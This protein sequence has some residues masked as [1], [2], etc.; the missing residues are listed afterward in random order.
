MHITP[1]DPRE[2]GLSAALAPIF[3]AAWYQLRYPEI[4]AT[5]LSP[6]RHFIRG[7]LV[8]LRD[9]NRFFDC[10]W[11]GEHYPDVGLSGLHPL[12]HYLRIGA[13]E[14]RDPH[15]RFDASFYAREHPEAA[16][17]PLLF[18]LRTG[19]ARAYPTEPPL[20]IAD[21]LPADTAIKAG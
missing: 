19:A 2:A 11:Y 17:N 3:D 16:G 7:G 6:I 21:Y 15:P 8:E 20:Q 10:I 1:E 5:G 18:H 13:A 12:L 4:A 9:P 14:L